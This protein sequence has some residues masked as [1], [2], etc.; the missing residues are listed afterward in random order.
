MAYFT[1]EPSGLTLEAFSMWC[2]TAPVALFGMSFRVA[3]CQVPS[4]SWEHPASCGLQFP[5]RCRVRFPPGNIP[6]GKL[7]TLVTH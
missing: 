6:S 2:V 1:L 3:A 4:A 5:A 7:G